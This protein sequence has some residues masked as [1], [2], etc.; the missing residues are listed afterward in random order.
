MKEIC[1]PLITY[2]CATTNVEIIAPMMDTLPKHFLDNQPWPEMT[3]NCKAA[4]SIAH[5]GRTIL[6]KYFVEEDVIKITKF[7]T[8]DQVHKDN[9]VEFF[10][11]F[12]P[13]QKYYNIEINCA[14]ICLIAYGEG[15][16]K[17][18]MLS[19]N[20]INKI[21]KMILIKSSSAAVTANFEWQITLMIPI[22]VFEFSDLQSLK[23]KEA[24]GNF[25]KCGDDLPEPHFLTW[26]KM[27]AETP[28][29]HL[30]QF[31]GELHFG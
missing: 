12:T 14:G 17:R 4:F 7:H 8:N 26:N 16:S 18:K 10:I 1:I 31:F 21:Q 22:E 5:T 2:D 23:D 9:C 15:R 30:P 24:V 6:L 25:Y 29:F 3:S 11:A 13:E 20:K 27:H 28:D 19:E